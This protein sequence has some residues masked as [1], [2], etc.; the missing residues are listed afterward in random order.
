M[1]RW[2][3]V[4]VTGLVALLVSGISGTASA[5]VETSQAL[6]HAYT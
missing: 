6:H 3:T 5:A 1:P 2:I 4:F